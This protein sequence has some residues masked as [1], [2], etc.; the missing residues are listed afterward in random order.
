MDI[1]IAQSP[2]ENKKVMSRIDFINTRDY[3]NR[4][5]IYTGLRKR[6]SLTARVGFQANWHNQESPN[7]SKASLREAFSLHKKNPSFQYIASRLHRHYIKQEIYPII[8]MTVN[9]DHLSHKL[10]TILKPKTIIEVFIKQPI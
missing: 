8:P 5:W 10:R 2:W 9:T 4:K 6:C 3:N 7:H 1:R